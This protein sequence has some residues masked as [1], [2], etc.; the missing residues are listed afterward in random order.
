MCY[1]QIGKGWRKMEH[2]SSGMRLPFE[3]LRR[4]H[5]DK[6]PKKLRACTMHT[7]GR[8]LQTERST[9]AKAMRWDCLGWG[10][11]GKEDLLEQMSEGT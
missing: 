11:R 6:D 7:Q 9:P 1:R 8:L 10:V 3:T 5:L 2:G 4:Y